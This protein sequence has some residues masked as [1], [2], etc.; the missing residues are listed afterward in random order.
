MTSN[1]IRR[2]LRLG[3]VVGNLFMTASGSFMLLRGFRQVALDEEAPGT[4]SSQ[5]AD[6]KSRRMIAGIDAAV[7]LLAFVASEALATIGA[8]SH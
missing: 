5:R 6:G 7:F 4:E 8:L 1:F 3:A 2:S